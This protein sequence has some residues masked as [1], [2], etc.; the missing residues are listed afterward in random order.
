MRSLEQVRGW[1][2]SLLRDEAKFSLLNARLILRTGVNLAS[3]KQSQSENQVAI[4]KV[5]GA[6]AE[7]GYRSDR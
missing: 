2:N 3:I 6:L 1:L 7:M 4:A 5:L